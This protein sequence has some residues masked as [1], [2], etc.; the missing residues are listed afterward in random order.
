VYDA[1]QVPY[2][3]KQNDP[4]LEP[5]GVYEVSAA[6][7]ADRGTVQYV[8]YTM[9]LGDDG[10]YLGGYLP[11]G[12]DPDRAEP[13]NVAYMAHGIF[14]D[15]TDFMIPIS[16]PIILDN[17]T[18]RGEIEPTV[19]ITMGNHFTGTGLYFASYNQQNAADNLVQTIIPFVEENY[20]V[21]NER[22][23]RAYGG[24]SYGAMTSSQVMRSY[25]TAFGYYGLIS[26]APGP[27]LTAQ[28]YDDFAA[29][30]G[31]SG[32]SVFLGNGFFETFPD[33]REVVADNLRSRGI[34]A[35]TAQVPGAHDGSTASQ[36]FTIWAKDYLWKNADTPDGGTGRY[37][38]LGRVRSGRRVR[39]RRSEADRRPLR[40]DAPGAHP[41]G[42]LVRR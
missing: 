32:T 31:T 10:N 40:V 6:D 1:V 4:I 15:E 30:V 5:R 18:A 35:E 13:Y 39:L 17:L 9:I 26:G 27:A 22:E 2:A 8:E 24:F 3:E 36:L 19:M 42:G 29:A 20:N 16:A 23:G 12:Y 41:A 7:P 25:P 21:S 14:G 11:A 38:W 28:D 34:P 33:S 37:W